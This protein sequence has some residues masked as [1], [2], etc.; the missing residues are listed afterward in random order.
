MTRDPDIGDVYTTL[1]AEGET[2]KIEFP[3]NTPWRPIHAFASSLAAAQGVTLVVSQR[4][5][6]GEEIVGCFAPDGSF[7]PDWEDE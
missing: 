1:T 6:K 3:A 7:H 4:C 5:E 2:G